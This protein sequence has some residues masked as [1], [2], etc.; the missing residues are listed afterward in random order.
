MPATKTKTPF[1]KTT[2]QN[3]LHL[4]QIANHVDHYIFQSYADD[5]WGS[6]Y[7]NLPGYTHQRDLSHLASLPDKL[8]AKTK[9]TIGFGDK[10]EGWSGT[11]DSIMQKNRDLAPHA[12]QGSFGVW[13]TGLFQKEL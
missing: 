13:S 5:A 4:N 10:V 2:L 11:P 1:S 9:Y 12:R 6:G 8:K 7:M 3:G